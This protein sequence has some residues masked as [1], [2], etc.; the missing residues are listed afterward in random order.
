M[1]T[2]LR[3]HVCDSAQSIA[4]DQGNDCRYKSTSGIASIP[5]PR[6]AVGMA[7]GAYRRTGLLRPLGLDGITAGNGRALRGRAIGGAAGVLGAGEIWT[8]VATFVLIGRAVTAGRF[9]EGTVTGFRVG[10]CWGL[11]GAMVGGTAVGSGVA[12]MD[13]FHRRL[14]SSRRSTNLARSRRSSFRASSVETSVADFSRLFKALTS[15]SRRIN[16]RCRPCCT[17]LSLSK[18]LLPGCRS[19]AVAR[20]LI[21]KSAAPRANPP[22]DASP[23]A[24]ARRYLNM[25][26][27]LS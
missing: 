20:P 4:H 11:T 24:L 9:D 6:K 26:K 21:R 18:P 10:G 5:C 12:T 7:P 16:S 22:D 27:L 15:N 17:A 3:G 25:T 1:P 19:S 8:G 23:K 2:A 14:R 13:S